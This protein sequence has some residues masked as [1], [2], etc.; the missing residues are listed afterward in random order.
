MS[1]KT[2]KSKKESTDSKRADSKIESGSAPFSKLVDE[3]TLP[4]IYD[5]DTVCK[6]DPNLNSDE[7]DNLSIP[8]LPRQDSEDKYDGRNKATI[9][10]DIFAKAIIKVISSDKQVMVF[11]MLVKNF[12]DKQGYFLS[13]RTI[14]Q[15][16]CDMI[17]SKLERQGYFP[18]FIG[19]FKYENG[20]ACDMRI[21]SQDK[22]LGEDFYLHDRNYK[23]MFFLPI[24][25]R[26][27]LLYMFT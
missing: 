12:I 2:F 15:C 4:G 19:S 5:D 26:K 24:W 11:P 21:K 14:S 17:D 7:I 25:K 6:P 23:D 20:F 27:D 10:F 3:S 8:P 1:P 18:F 9:Y 16:I 13:L 22:S